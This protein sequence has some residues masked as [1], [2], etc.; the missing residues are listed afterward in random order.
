M[1]LIMM[2]TGPFAVPLFRA[3]YETRHRVT[4]L[5][6]APLRSHRGQ[7]VAPISSIRDVAQE[8]GTPI[9]EPED[10]NTPEAQSRLAEYHADLLVVCDY[11][12]ILSPPT[13]ATTRRGGVNL[14][15]SLLPKYRGAAPINWAIY[16]GESETGVTVLEITPRIDAGGCLAQTRVAIGPEET[17]AELEV[18]LAQIGARLTCETIDRLESGDI[19]AIPQ[20]AALVTKAPRLKK[21]D[22]AID[23]SRPALAIKNQIRALEPWPK[24]YTFWHRPDGP[25]IRLI[26]GP[27]TVV[28]PRLAAAG[29]A[30]PGDSVG[31]AVELPP[32][33]GRVLEASGDRLVIAAGTDAVMP[34]S[35]QPSG[36]RPMPIAEF[37][38]GYHV[39]PGDQLGAEKL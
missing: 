16:N 3:L 10:V 2:G 24:T 15:A 18:R 26:L 9:V 28:N 23:W 6:T 35:V 32:Q 25:P 20:D 37:L 12:Q 22:G 29:T 13:L 38:R 30:A 11:G 17:A 27:A 14:H 1:Q 36:K 31:V 33:P 19:R 39:R 7:P 4:A 8:H 34:A 5:V 21:T